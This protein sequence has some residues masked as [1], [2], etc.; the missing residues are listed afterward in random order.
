MMLGQDVN[1][2]L[3]Q[4]QK[5]LRED[6]IRTRV[7]DLNEITNQFVQEVN[8]VIGSRKIFGPCF[9]YEGMDYIKVALNEMHQ[10]QHLLG[11]FGID[12]EEKKQR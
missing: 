3:Y 4:S 5:R 2:D 7:A 1:N 12:T 6:V 8:S 11:M 10:L 9:I